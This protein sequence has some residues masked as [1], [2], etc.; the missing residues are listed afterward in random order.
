MGSLIM[1]HG[2]VAGLSQFRL[3]VSMREREIITCL[4][5]SSNEISQELEIFP[6]LSCRKSRE[7]RWGFSKEWDPKF[8]GCRATL[9]AIKLDRKSTRLNSSHGYISYA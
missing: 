2:A 5:L 9:Q 8:N 7:S 6:T 4:S 3:L 1:R